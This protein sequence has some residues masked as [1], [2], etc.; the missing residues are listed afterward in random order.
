MA[1][2]D[3]RRLNT[4]WCT[5]YAGNRSP[6]NGKRSIPSGFSYKNPVFRTYGTHRISGLFRPCVHWGT[7]LTAR[8]VGSKRAVLL[9]FNRFERASVAVRLVVLYC[10]CARNDN[11]STKRNPKCLR[12]TDI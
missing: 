8:N 9:R 1:H 11:G 3:M 6:S 2:L 12:I 4:C 5:D 7:F 10:T